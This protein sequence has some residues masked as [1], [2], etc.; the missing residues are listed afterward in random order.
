[1][2]R[3]STVRPQKFTTW[4][5][6][7]VPLADAFTMTLVAVCSSFDSDW[8]WGSERNNNP[9][10][11]VFI[12]ERV[13][14]R[15]CLEFEEQC[16]SLRDSPGNSLRQC[17]VCGWDL[18]NRSARYNIPSITPVLLVSLLRMLWKYTHLHPLGLSICLL[19]SAQAITLSYFMDRS[20]LEAPANS[21]CFSLFILVWR[22]CR[23]CYL[24]YWYVCQIDCSHQRLN[25]GP[26]KFN[27]D[28]FLLNLKRF[29]H[30]TLSRSSI[31]LE[32][33][34][35]FSITDEDYNVFIRRI[36]CPLKIKM[37]YTKM[38]GLK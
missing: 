30:L 20:I 27:S 25:P 33:I 23:I 32:L 22:G 16:M 10:F 38:S 24:L 34:T 31:S 26:A 3:I 29:E 2:I 37:V 11:A 6:S 7:T 35:I 21:N 9:S 8:F 17:V 28:T 15:T 1:M 5:P 14:N 19:R 13:I 4:R 36:Y 12:S 18:C